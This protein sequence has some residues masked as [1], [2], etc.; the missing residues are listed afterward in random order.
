MN[1]AKL[2]VSAKL[3]GLGRRVLSLVMGATLLLHGAA[4]AQMP[5]LP[6]GPKPAEPPAKDPAKMPVAA[7]TKD[8]PEAVFAT[9]AG[10]IQVKNKVA[11][12]DVATTLNDLMLQ[13]PGVR[14][15]AVKVVD[16]VV[17]I[18]GLVDDR[19]TRNNVTE[20][21]K[22]VEGV[23]LVLNLMKTDEQV[24]TGR[25]M[26]MKSLRDVEFLV[27]QYWLLALIA[28]GYALGFAWL[29]KLFTRH[30]ETLLAPFVKNVLLRSVVGSLVS[31]G[32]LLAG[33]M[34]G[35]SVLNLT[36]AVTSVLGLAGVI[37]LA[38]GFAF[39]DIVENF[40]ASILLGTRRPFQIGD[41]I[42]VAGKSGSVLSLN[43]RATNLITP[44]GH[45]VRI[46]NAVIYKETLINSTASPSV[47]G[48]IEI[49]VPYETST[50]AAMEAITGALA[51][52]EGLIQSPAPR[53]LLTALENNGVRL[54]ATYW[55]P[56]KGM[57]NDKLQSDL[58]LRIKVAL[59]KAGITPQT[60]ST[61]LSVSGR[62][63]VE[64]LQA[65][66]DE[67]A[68]ARSNGSEP[69][70]S[71]GSALTARQAEANLR[72]DSRAAEAVAATPEEACPSPIDHAIRQAE[73]VGVGEGGNLLAHGNK[74]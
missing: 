48:S 25:Q 58:R 41:F 74:E 5:S 2:D 11:D 27:E 57:D 54:R 73:T 30:S 28:I 4:S 31:S 18:D 37:G 16:G 33:I 52:T 61:T 10:T 51:G 64:L 21:V 46:P 32:I 47:L 29:A 56:T 23:R 22:K 59:Q 36:R 70:A 66:H 13:Y 20:F 3:S 39:R 14:N 24:M 19:D 38:I 6:V 49:V 26:A 62:I 17:T 65:K 60:Q 50:A 72:K 40:I 55:M 35:L 12:E 1:S 69:V 15:A 34:L 53:C 9:T 45:Q 7:P 8:S 63:P 67:P 42:T 44:E 68:K 43:T 71:P